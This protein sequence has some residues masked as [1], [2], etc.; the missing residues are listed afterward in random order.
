MSDEN[1]EDKKDVLIE[2][3]RSELKKA[4][5]E[6]DEAQEALDKLEQNYRQRELARRNGMDHD[7]ID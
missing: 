7:Y 5:F 2:Y 6:R 3:L 1:T 4:R